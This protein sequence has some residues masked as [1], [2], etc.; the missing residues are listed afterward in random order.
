MQKPSLLADLVDIRHQIKSDAECNRDT[1]R[2]RD[3]DIG[4]RIPARQNDAATLRAWVAAIRQGHGGQ[5]RLAQ[6][7]IFTVIA[8]LW[9]FGLS[10]GWLLGD[11]ALD[12]DG[13]EPVNIIHALMILVGSQLLLLTA[14]LILLAFGLERVREAFAFINPAV[15]I[16]RLL[17]WMQPAWHPSISELLD[18][19]GAM[20]LHGIRRWL[21][22]YLAQHFAV[23]LNLGIIAVLFYLVTV[24][25]LAFGWST[26]L[27]VENQ[28]VSG[29]FDALSSPWQWILPAAAPNADLVEASRYYRL[30]TRLH[31]DTMLVAEL[32]IWWLFMLMCILVYGLLPRTLTLLYAGIRYDRSV[33]S[34]IRNTTGS[35]QVLMRMRSPLVSSGA[36]EAET[37]DG[38]GES[39]PPLRRRQI[40]RP[41]R[42]VVIEWSGVQ[43]DRPALSRS[44]ITAEQ[45]HS[46]GGKQSP[47]ADREMINRIRGHEFEAVVL[48]AG[49]WEPPMMEFIDFL[50]EL[51]EQMDASVM[52]IVYLVPAEKRE[53]VKPGDLETWESALYA[54]DDS[55]LYVEVQ[56]P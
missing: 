21:L 53:A 38:T 28:A 17:A 23:A 25:D 43:A 19:Q 34:A 13:S 47:D 41:L 45:F 48:V 36:D 22:V 5:G 24:S 32:G 11:M 18:E 15:W 37:V 7:G 56:P 33:I 29:W 46:A 6:R 51:C 49:S 35:A 30:Q 55:K 31:Q 14:L 2:Q 10:G 4:L 39:P 9:L 26:T 3:R 50:R 44:G 40:G 27:V 1:V 16:S 54:M 52:R 20:R 12:Y 8:A 42:A